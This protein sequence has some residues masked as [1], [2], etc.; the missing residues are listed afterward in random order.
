FDG[1]LGRKE[2]VVM[3]HLVPELVGHLDVLLKDGLGSLIV[4]DESLGNRAKL[5]GVGHQSRVCTVVD[6]EGSELVRFANRRTEV[7]SDSCGGDLPSVVQ[8]DLERQCAE[9]VVQ[10]YPISY[11]SAGG[12]KQDVYLLV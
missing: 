6:H 3:S 12:L 11:E 7:S 9:Q 10:E 2:Q 1:I 8:R 4:H 5:R